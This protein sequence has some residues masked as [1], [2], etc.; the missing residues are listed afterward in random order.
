MTREDPIALR[1]RELLQRSASLRTQIGEDAA[2]VVS[3]AP[4]L[5]RGVRIARTASSNSK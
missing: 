4:W 5:E 3:S 2:T 1:R